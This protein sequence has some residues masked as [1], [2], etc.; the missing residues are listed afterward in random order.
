MDIVEIV[1]KVCNFQ[2]L[3]YQ[4]DFVRKVYDAAKMING[5][6]TFLHEVIIDLVLNCYRHWLLLYLDKNADY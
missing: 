3:D 1:E 4:K 6:I 5:Y 2:L